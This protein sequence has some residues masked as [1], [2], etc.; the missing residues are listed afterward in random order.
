[1]GFGGGA[2]GIGSFLYSAIDNTTITL[3]LTTGKIRVGIIENTQVNNSNNFT[4]PILQNLYSANLGNIAISNP[5]PVVSNGGTFDISQ[6][7]S[8]ATGVGNIAIGAGVL[9]N[10][11]SG[12]ANCGIGVGSLQANTTGS[13]NSAYGS[14]ALQYN[15]TGSG[16][17]AIGATSLYANTTGEYNIAIGFSALNPYNNTTSTKGFNIAIG[18]QTGINYNG[19]ETNN[20]LIGQVLGTAGENNMLRI[21]N[22]G[23]GIL[24]GNLSTNIMDVITTEG[25]STTAGISTTITAGTSPYTYTN[26]SAS[27]QEVFISGGVI[28]ALSFEPA[29]ANPLTINTS[30]SVIILRPNDSL[31]ITYTTAPDIYTI[32]L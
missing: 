30:T 20:I 9:T 10:D 22:T 17:V 8:T 23:D 11:T 32:Q 18:Y 28:T 16:N 5:S 6:F 21:G 1:M 31:E 15:T 27:N 25:I 7:P 24:V 26:T 13:N 19:N 4:L 29:G 3:D 14:S 12:E 2:F